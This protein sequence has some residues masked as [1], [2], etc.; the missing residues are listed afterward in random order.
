MSLFD[1]SLQSI[2]VNIGHITWPSKT[3]I[4]PNK[5]NISITKQFWYILTVLKLKYFTHLN[6]K[7]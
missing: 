4:S 5:G 2:Y 3:I 6:E 1:S 7:R